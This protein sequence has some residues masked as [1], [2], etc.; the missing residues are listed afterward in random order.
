MMREEHNGLACHAPLV[1]CGI[2]QGPDFNAGNFDPNTGDYYVKES[3]GIIRKI[4]FI[5]SWQRRWACGP[6]L[7]CMVF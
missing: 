4:D 2:F 1:P 3:G 7:G 5:E 6:E